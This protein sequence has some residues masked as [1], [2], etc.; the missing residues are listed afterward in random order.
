FLLEVFY[1]REG[2]ALLSDGRLCP[3]R[4][5][6]L[7][8]LAQFD[9]SRGGW[10]LRSREVDRF[11]TAD[12]VLNE[13][14]VH[15][16]GGARV[17]RRFDGDGRLLQESAGGADDRLDGPFF[18]RFPASEPSPY[19]DARIRQERGAWA[20]GQAI[21]RWTFM[22]DG[23]NVVRAVDRGAALADGGLARLL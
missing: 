19:A 15:G 5:E 23:G 7:S 14:V 11:W 21:G 3:R 9:E 18:R 12:G 16:E 8:D 10:A 20:G 13:E 2:R 17:V 22:D 1:D 4:P 6:G